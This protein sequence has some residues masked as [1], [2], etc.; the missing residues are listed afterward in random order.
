MSNPCIQFPF[1]VSVYLSSIYFFLPHCHPS[2]EWD[3]SA[4]RKVARS[5]TSSLHATIWLKNVHHVIYNN[6]SRAEF[7]VRGYGAS[8]KHARM[9]WGNFLCCSTFFL[10]QR[11]IW[12]CNMQKRGKLKELGG[13]KVHRKIQPEFPFFIMKIYE[14]TSCFMATLF[15]R[16]WLKILENVYEKIYHME[17]NFSKEFLR[18]NLVADIYWTVTRRF[19]WT[20]LMKYLIWTWLNV[21]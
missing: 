9:E 4:P 12:Q 15:P 7:S 2:D 5:N 8:E 18:S 11:K 20:F 3:I 13:N 14:L 21:F 19:W 16:E 17:Q 1:I 6:C 10:S